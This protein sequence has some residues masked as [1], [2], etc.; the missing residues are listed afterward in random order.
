MTR[1]GLP[2]GATTSCSP[3]RSA[4]RTERRRARR[5]DDREDDALSD[6]AELLARQVGR[7]AIARQ[8]RDAQVGAGLAYRLDRLRAAHREQTQRP[9]A[10]GEAAD[11]GAEQVEK[12]ALTRREH[13]R[14]GLGLAA[15]L[16]EHRAAA[17]LDLAAER[18][19]VAPLRRERQGLAVAAVERPTHRLGQLLYLH[20]QRRLGDVEARG[21]ACEVEV[22]GEHHEGEQPLVSHPSMTIVSRYGCLNV[23]SSRTAPSRVACGTG[24]PRWTTSETTRASPS[25]TRSSRACGSTLAATPPPTASITPRRSRPGRPRWPAPTA[26]ARPRQRCSRTSAALTTSAR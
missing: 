26:A 21:G 8:G 2:A 14:A 23:T 13:D 24:E 9:G 17:L 12:C 15:Q 6:G 4:G 7:Q 25:A 20:V 1:C 3:A 5:W 10:L 18:G 22:L 19:Q 16:L 11:G